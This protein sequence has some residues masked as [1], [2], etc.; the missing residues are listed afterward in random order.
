[1]RVIPIQRMTAQ[2]LAK[3]TLEPVALVGAFCAMQAQEY[4]QAKWAVGL[5]APGTTD[6]DIETLLADGE[7]LR[8]HPMRGTHHFVARDDL[9]WLMALMGPVMIARSANRNRQLG[10]DE[11]TLSKCM[12]LIERALAGGTHLTRAEIVTVLERA[13]IN[14][15]G[16]RIAHIIYRA[17]LESLVCS[18]RRKGKQITLALFDERV[19]AAKAIPRDEA[20]ARLAARYVATRSPATVADF[21]WWCQLPMADA[22]AGFESARPAKQKASPPPKALLLPP[23][24]EFTVSYKDRSALGTPPPRS[25]AAKF[26]EWT[27]LGP[28]IVLGGEVCG[29]WS[30]TITPKAVKV[31]LSPWRALTGAEQLAVSKQANRYA[32]FVGRS[33]T[34]IQL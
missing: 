10:L 23:Y 21:Q 4:E 2:H 26:G 27:M 15:E 16:Q 8:S 13:K 1:M 3:S 18:G 30:R 9:R 32:T 7:I 6:A 24:D 29:T 19:P 22:R 5:R 34:E 33:T 28:V 14:T 11:K 12:A 17:E 20:I 31:K 25:K